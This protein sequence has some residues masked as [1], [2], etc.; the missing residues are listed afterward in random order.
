MPGFV[1]MI[2]MGLLKKFT[3]VLPKGL[4]FLLPLFPFRSCSRDTWHLIDTYDTV[5]IVTA[6]LNFFPY[7]RTLFIHREK[8]LSRLSLNSSIAKKTTF[9]LH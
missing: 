5:V 6:V 1:S 8:S 4:T 3:W 9:V 2:L 7:Y